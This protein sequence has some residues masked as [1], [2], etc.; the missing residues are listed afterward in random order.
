MQIARIFQIVLVGLFVIQPISVWSQLKGTYTI[1][2]S[3]SDYSSFESFV[4]DFN[5]NGVNG[6]VVLN[7][8]TDINLSKTVVISVPKSN[9][10]TVKSRLIINGKGK[11]LIGNLKREMI[12]FN[13]VDHVWIKNLTL[14]N[15][16]SSSSLMGIRFS[17]QADSNTIDSCV[18]SFNKLKSISSQPG[19]YVVF[20]Q[21]DSAIT[22]TPT[23]FSNGKNNTISNCLMQST[24]GS[25]GPN[26]GILDFQNSINYSYTATNNSFLNNR[27][28]NFYSIGIY[29]RYVNGEQIIGNK[30]SRSNASSSDAV[31]SSLKAIYMEEAY[32]LTRT[33]RI[34]NNEISNLPYYGASLSTS[35]LSQFF[36]VH[37]KYVVADPTNSLVVSISGNYIHD[38]VSSELSH[39]IFTEYS[40]GIDIFKNVIRNLKISSGGMFGI[41]GSYGT[42]HKINYNTV[43]ACDFGSGTGKSNGVAIYALDIETSFYTM[44]EIQN[45]QVDS[46]SAS[47]E[48]YGISSVWAGSWTVKNN[49][50]SHNLSKGNSSGIA[51]ATY[52][53]YIKNLDFIGNLL[54]NNFGDAETHGLYTIN[55]NSGNSL[56]IIQN[57]FYDRDDNNSGHISSMVYVDDDSNIDFI[58]NV[59]DGKG[60][61]TGIVVS[62]FTYNTI[63]KVS[64][65][66]IYS[67]YSTEWWAI[68]TNSFSDFSSWKNSGF[69]DDDNFRTVAKFVDVAKGDFRSKN[70]MNQNNVISKSISK[71]D[72]T[73]KKRNPIASDRGCF[74]DSMNI[75]MVRAHFSLG[76]SICNGFETNI[77][78]TIAN[79]YSDTIKELTLGYSFNGKN[80]TEKIKKTILPQDTAVL[81]FANTVKLNAS[82]N[83]SLNVYVAQSNDFIK[84]DTIKFKTFVKKA[85]GGSKITL[86]TVAAS[87]NNPYLI[88][89][90]KYA[91]YNGLQVG[92]DVTPPT[93][94]NRSDYGAN[95]KWMAST[96]AKTLGGKP[97][98]GS[99]VVVPTSNTDLKWSFLTTDTLLEDSTI[100]VQLKLTDNLNG[101]DTFLNVSV[102]VSPSPKLN[103][104]YPTKLCS[105]DTI[106][107]VNK[108]TI[109]G[110]NSFMEFTW[111]FGTSSMDSST[112]IDGRFI[113]SNGGNYNVKLIAKTYPYG[114]LFEKTATLSVTQ[115][116]VAKFT[117]NS[118]CEGQD[119]LFSNTSSDTTATM[120]WNFGDNTG[121][122][123]VSKMN[124]GYKYAKYATYNVML[125][126]NKNGC[127]SSAQSKVTVFENPKVGFTISGGTCMGDKFTFSNTTVMNT[128][129]FGVVWNFDENG[130]VSTQKSTNYTYAKSGVKNVKL[131]I[132]TEFGCSDSI[133]KTLTVK[134]A[135]MPDFTVGRLCLNSKTI[136]ENKTPKIA[137]TSES[138]TWYV[139]N[140]QVS[141]KDSIHRSWNK[142]G[143]YTVR[144]NVLLDNGCTANSEKVVRVL[145]EV[146]PQFTFE[147]VCSGDTVEFLNKTE[148]MASDSIR[149]HW[150]FGNG[151]TLSAFS[152]SRN[153]KPLQT[154]TY[155]VT[156]KAQLRN[157]CESSI[158]KPV[159]IYELPKTCDF[160]FT[161]AYESAFWGIKLEPKNSSGLIG[162]QEGVNYQWNVKGMGNKNSSNTNAAVI[163]DLGSDGSFEASMIASTSQKGC[164]CR[165]NKTIVMN[166]SQIKNLKSQAMV[167]YPNPTE[168]N[169]IILRSA[170]LHKENSNQL[171]VRDVLGRNISF[172]QVQL[173]DGEIELELGDIASGLYFVEVRNSKGSIKGQFQKL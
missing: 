21:V 110:K 1:G 38:N 96:S 128:S 60:G 116:P 150:D 6:D 107:F 37:I 42:D 149:Y 8:N 147:E 141:I 55:Y 93:G 33:V 135:P 5:N 4:N 12:H 138:K 16:F 22:K 51:A 164:E 82:G 143:N 77:K 73:G 148:L 66:S 58:G 127:S 94:F 136:F 7:F 43:S 89:S 50:V 90:N 10:T 162:G 29:T 85:P 57:T 99:S 80:V 168:T 165:M 28:T 61:G 75:R 54:A 84:D 19:A 13:G 25:P 122:K 113:Y 44:N 64:S 159:T 11:K 49:R 45:N 2:T 102:H 173:E 161:T 76:D 130:A 48:F 68:E 121:D 17:N 41:L 152:A 15:Q 124:F 78:V 118:G 46:N 39:G 163:Y 27:I 69:V 18:I 137:G 92:F 88:S 106:H 154:Q 81:Q 23:G 108:S 91:T 71:T 101:C 105:S 146:N 74:E 132:N 56:N 9:P 53:L 114:F 144:L 125:T 155:N 32:T 98:S 115:T 111:K 52:F 151:D 63:G 134:P 169:K 156:L 171:T 131:V 62:L 157:G 47:G 129:L 126:A 103:F 167:I 40:E 166:R 160:E 59:V 20:A 95:K 86:S 14:E 35:S 30:I 97:I 109:K 70:I 104:V 26:Y 140:N 117:R 67:D 112:D 123:T 153:Y 79:D 72:L 87:K 83:Q 24:G 120:I 142:V 158:V 36:G 133:T 170:D 139:D 3:G 31:D 172:K 100:L 145:N 65:N 34:D 119:I